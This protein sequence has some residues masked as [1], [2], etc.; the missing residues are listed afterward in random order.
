MYVAKEAN[1]VHSNAWMLF[2]L[3]S[4]SKSVLEIK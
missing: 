3:K 4:I 1:T 2:S